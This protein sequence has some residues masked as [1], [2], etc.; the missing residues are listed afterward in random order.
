[1]S[2]ISDVIPAL[3][4][5]PVTPSD[6][7]NL[8]ATARALYIGSGGDVVAI[9]GDGTAVTFASVQTGTILPIFTK[10]VNASSTTADDIVALF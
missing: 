9:N 3:N 1:M 10:R 4:F 5:L 2:M 6:T 7:V 8:P